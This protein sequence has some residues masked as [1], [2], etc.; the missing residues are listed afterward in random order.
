VENSTSRAGAGGAAVAMAAVAE[1]AASTR[2]KWRPRS[3]RRAMTALILGREEPALDVILGGCGLTS[4]L[5]SGTGNAVVEMTQWI[6]VR[7]VG[8]LN[9]PQSYRRR[10]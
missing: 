2:W 5:H 8:L 9:F 4:S 1:E 3:M 10:D 7:R 6:V